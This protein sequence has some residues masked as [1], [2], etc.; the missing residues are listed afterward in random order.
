M[1]QIL[2]ADDDRAMREMVVE[3]LTAAGYSVRTVSDGATA[4]DQVRRDP[5][6][7]ALLDYR[8]GQPDG[9][10][11]CRRIKSDPQLE[12]VPV[13]I[14]TAEG[15]LDNR[16][17]GFDAGANDYLP[18]PFDARELI[19]RVGALLALSEQIRGLNPSTGL[20]G[21]T[22]IQR[23]FDRR[24]AL[25][26]PF[27]LC[28]LDLENFKAFNDRFGFAK[29]NRVIESMG[30]CLRNAVTGSRSFTGHVGGDDFVLIC[31]P[32]V[33]RPLVSTVQRNLRQ[34]MRK[35]LPA[36]VVNRGGYMGR[37]RDGREEWVRLTRL[38]TVILYVNPAAMP[39]L[40]VLAETAAEGKGHAKAAT[41]EGILEIE[42]VSADER[43]WERPA[44]LDRA[45]EVDLEE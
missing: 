12:H 15:D 40:N 45:L 29:A 23:E 19:A 22:R 18:K 9:F 42:V 1:A 17:R 6:D 35:L 7:L 10:E 41:D 30:D 20:P 21:G 3:V 43:R 5:P 37:L 24:A 25:G 32:L 31:D 27:A 28:Y 44:A 8:M 34:E 4:L 38:T 39:P 26:E 2:F 36:E 16:I 13:L 11:V 14:L 33:A